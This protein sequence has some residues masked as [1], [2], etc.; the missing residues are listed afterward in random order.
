M[1]PDQGFLP[2]T[3]FVQIL[4]DEWTS[5]CSKLKRRTQALQAI[6]TALTFAHIFLAFISAASIDSMM[7]QPQPAATVHWLIK[8]MTNID[9]FSAWHHGAIALKEHIIALHND[10]TSSVSKEAATIVI[11]NSGIEFRSWQVSADIILDQLC[12][13][14]QATMEVYQKSREAYMLMRPVM[15]FQLDVDQDDIDI[16]TE[17]H[18]PAFFPIGH[19]S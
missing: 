8:L 3:D 16:D 19:I 9:D 12:C 4:R 10:I 18:L 6:S 13:Q 15:L 7:A 1:E 2:E 14:C 17:F 11:L 5:V